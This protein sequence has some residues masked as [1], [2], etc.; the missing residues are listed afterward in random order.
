MLDIDRYLSRIGY[1]GSRAPTPATLNA[2]HRRH[3]LAVPFENL[4]IPL[5]RPIVLD[6]ALLHEKI[7]GRGRGG[8]CYELNGIFA[9]LL[10]ALGFDVTLF[11][12]R[13]V[14][15]DGEFGIPFDHLTLCVALEERWLADVGFG[16]SFVE[17]LRLDDAGLQ[18]RDGVAYRVAP[19]GDERILWQAEKGEMRRQ[20]TFTQNPRRLQDFADACRYHQTSPDSP[21]T[22]RRVCTRATPD[23][24]ITLSDGRLIVTRNGTR[25]ERPL[26]AGEET[27][28]LREHFAITLGGEPHAA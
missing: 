18:Y 26:S 28:I 16:D 19:G 17:P 7:V 3:L 14:T 8:F 21:F 11:S 12:A 27:A 5:G 10:R 6:E 25:T 4:D 20:Y 23:G 24:R 1:S 13:V 15:Q 2:L 22:R 9:A